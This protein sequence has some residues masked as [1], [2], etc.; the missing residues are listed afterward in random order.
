[1][2]LPLVQGF[3]FHRPLPAAGI[4][5]LLARAERAQQIPA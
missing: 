2:R 1:M 5:K 3:L 4:T